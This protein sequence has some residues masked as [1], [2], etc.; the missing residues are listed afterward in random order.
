MP[1]ARSWSAAVGL[2]PAPAGVTLTSIG[3]CTLSALHAASVAA[4]AAASAPRPVRVRLIRIGS[5]PQ[6]DGD[7]ELAHAREGAEVDEAVQVR[8]AEVVE[9]RVVAPVV[10]LHPEVAPLEAEPHG[11]RAEP[12]G[13]RLRRVE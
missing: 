2:A 7:G 11:V 4:A 1:V 10:G 3:V 13:D 8:V 6:V 5:E 9:L 12:L